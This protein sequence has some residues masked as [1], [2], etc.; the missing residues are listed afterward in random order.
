MYGYA[1]NGGFTACVMVTF[2]GFKPTSWCELRVAVAGTYVAPLTHLK[3]SV[4]RGGRTGVGVNTN[5][6][7]H[8]E[9]LDNVYAGI[10]P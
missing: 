7:K 4:G 9:C 10:F 1:S 5:R 3:R 6:F 2:C 8:E